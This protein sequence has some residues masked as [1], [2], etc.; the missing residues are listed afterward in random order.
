MIFTAFQYLEYSEATFTITD[1]IFGTVFFSSTGLHGIHVIIGT[2]FIFLGL[3]RLVNYHLL[4][5][6][7]VGL[8]SAILY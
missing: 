4:D 2:I 1:S 8:E 3:L 7:H 5:T 6:H